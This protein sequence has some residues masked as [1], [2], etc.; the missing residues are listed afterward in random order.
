MNHAAAANQVPVEADAAAAATAAD[1]AAAAA[2]AANGAARIEACFGRVRA[3]NARE[4]TCQCKVINV[5]APGEVA[6]ASTCLYDTKACD[7]VSEV[8]SAGRLLDCTQGCAPS[9]DDKRRTLNPIRAVFSTWCWMEGALSGRRVGRSSARDPFASH[10]E[11]RVMC[12][13]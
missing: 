1:H 2:A 7:H 6:A 12:D 8:S 3:R 5:C 4:Q 9:S 10:L 13:V 11:R